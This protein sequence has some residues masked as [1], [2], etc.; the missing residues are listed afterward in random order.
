MI[1]EQKK[2]L[3]CSMVGFFENQNSWTS[4][5]STI[6]QAMLGKMPVNVLLLEDHGVRIQLRSEK[7]VDE[8]LK[9]AE[10]ISSPLP[11]LERWMDCLGSPPNPS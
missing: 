2:N 10:G 4:A 9:S 3:Y 8:V 11:V 1:K 5:D 6:A 7:E